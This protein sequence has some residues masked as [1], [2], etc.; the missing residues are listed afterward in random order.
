[1]YLKK[2]RIIMIPLLLSLL[3]LF[4]SACQADSNQNT[5]FENNDLTTT[6]SSDSEETP[7]E[8]VEPRLKPDLPEKDFEGLEIRLLGRQHE[9]EMT[10]KHFSE[11]GSEEENGELMNDAIYRRNRTIEGR[12]NVN[13]KGIISS[14]RGSLH[15][16]IRR[17]VLAGDNAFDA[18]F[19]SINDSAR[20][21]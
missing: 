10:V 2:K 17:S 1:M 18:A 21:S 3:I 9:P 20:L 14:D 8:T 16:D 19:S 12:Y 15:G 5:N 6:G 4:I 11:T 7:V 13:I